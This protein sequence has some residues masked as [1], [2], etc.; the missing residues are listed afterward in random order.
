MQ[1][2]MLTMGAPPSVFY[3]TTELKDMTS[4]QI[5]YLDLLLVEL[6]EG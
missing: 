6:F 3:R 4:E 2:F 1:D 5:S